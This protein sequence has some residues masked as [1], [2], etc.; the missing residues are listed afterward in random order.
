M[1]IELGES[2]GL[3]DSKCLSCDDLPSLPC[4]QKLVLVDKGVVVNGIA[5]VT[6][7]MHDEKKGYKMNDHMK[8][9]WKNF[10]VSKSLAPS[11]NNSLWCVAELGEGYE[12]G[13]F[14]KSGVKGN[15]EKSECEQVALETNMIVLREEGLVEVGERG[16]SEVNVKKGNV[17]KHG[18]GEEDDD[19]RI[20]FYECDMSGVKD[21]NHETGLRLESLGRKKG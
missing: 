19:C 12:I 17:S 4:K 3:G 20:F 5:N 15:E 13:E 9:P 14:G 1:A 18:R 16:K 21:L 11:W 6:T 10:F 2:S 8:G 7:P